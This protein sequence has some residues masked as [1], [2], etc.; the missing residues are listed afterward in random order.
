VGFLEHLYLKVEKP[1]GFKELESWRED[2]GLAFM[3]LWDPMPEGVYIN[4]YSICQI[5]NHHPVT[6]S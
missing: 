3:E 1:T 4:D 6:M 5:S 2:E